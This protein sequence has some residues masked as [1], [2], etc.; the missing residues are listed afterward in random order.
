MYTSQVPPT[1]TL[2]AARS[3]LGEL[4][5]RAVFGREPVILTEH[6]R[7]VAAII[8]V[9]ELAGLQA[10]ADAAELVLAR[11]IVAAGGER[12]PHGDVLAAMDALDAADAATTP[13]EASRLLAPHA[14]VLARAEAAAGLL[15]DQA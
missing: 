6:G 10:A 9:E 15:D 8:S 14:A 5:N 3:R 11:R 1:F 13:E 2:T 12:I 4:V 7:Q